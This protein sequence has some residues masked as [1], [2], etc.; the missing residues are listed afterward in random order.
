MGA[1]SK[2]LA[3]FVFKYK[4]V[5]KAASWKIFLLTLGNSSDFLKGINKK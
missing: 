4:S 3:A 1:V 5:Y 2:L